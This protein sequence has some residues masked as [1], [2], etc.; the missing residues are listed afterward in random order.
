MVPR[1]V[2][3]QIAYARFDEAIGSQQNETHQMRLCTTASMYGKL[4]LTG[5]GPSG[6]FKDEMTSLTHRHH[7]HSHVASVSA[8]IVV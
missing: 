7:H 2:C 1:T 6:N 3:Q 5:G 4:A 8:E